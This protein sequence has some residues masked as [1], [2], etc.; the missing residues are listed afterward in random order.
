MTSYTRWTVKM[1]F[2]TLIGP[3]LGELFYQLDLQTTD[4][5]GARRQFEIH[6]FP[7][8]QIPHSPD[9][10]ESSGETQMYS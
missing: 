6:D 10:K 4:I 7:S 2:C 8:P 3:N 5:K 9:A 1:G